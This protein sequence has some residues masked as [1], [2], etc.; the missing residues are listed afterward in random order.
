MST[1]EEEHTAKA[2]KKSKPGTEKLPEVNLNV[3]PAAGKPGRFLAVATGAGGELH[4]DT[5]DLNSAVARKR[6]IK[7]VTAAV[8]RNVPGTEKPTENALTAV[9]SE[10]ENRLLAFAKVPPGN[11]EPPPA[12]AEDADDPRIEAL[13]KMSEDL[14]AEA[15]SLLENPELLRRISKDIESQGIVGE[16][17]LALTIYLVGVSAQ[18]ARPISAIVRGSSSSGKSYVTARVAGLFPPEVVLYATS[19]T[20]N[21]L[22]YAP[23]G[24]LRHRWIVAGERSRMEDDD[25]AEA[26]R[27]LREMIESGRLSK[28]A[29][30]K[31]PDGT[32]KAELIEQE[33]PIAF[34]ESTTLGRIFEEDANRCLLLASDETEEQTRRI[35][36]ATARAASGAVQGETDRTRAVHHAIQRM[37]PRV[38][39]TVPFAEG[40]AESFP[41]DRL[42]GRRSFRHLIQLVRAVALLHFRQRQRDADGNV[43]AEPADYQVAAVL[44]SDP[45]AASRGDLGDSTRRF[46]EAI[47]AVFPEGEFDS[48]Q[49]QEAGR[50]Q[51]SAARTRL[52]E[53][54]AVGL[55]VQ[56][57]EPKG[58]KPAR[59]RLTDKE[60]TEITGGL[61]SVE[62]VTKWISDRT[63]GRTT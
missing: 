3:T 37:I 39:V 49:A 60:P 28:L 47:K 26:T 25:T 40:I 24:I 16:A 36:R 12:A 42:D 62:Q 46:F 38:G 43:V 59:W 51:R 55:I 2:K 41:S 32:N 58:N 18:L 53:L 4:R 35:L 5:I 52:S 8:M 61:P 10:L 56:T 23:P 45:L 21:S 11:S 15:A 7:D 14:R 34:T 31:Q 54:A 20:T 1:K 33:G 19:L 17:R 6:F 48:N 29:T 44:A 22:Y 50:L 27:A 13:G 9:G 63:Q 30:V 57:S